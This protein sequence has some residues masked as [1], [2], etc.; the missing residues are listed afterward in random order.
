MWCFCF[1]AAMLSWVLWVSPG[2]GPCSHLCGVRW[3]S[4]LATSPVLAHHLST[5]GCFHGDHNSLHGYSGT[6]A[7]AWGTCP[8]QDKVTGGQQGWQAA[9]WGE[10]V[11]GSS[12]RTL[13]HCCQPQGKELSTWH[14]LSPAVSLWEQG[15]NPIPINHPAPKIP[16][17]VTACGAGSRVPPPCRCPGPQE[18][19]EAQQQGPPQ[20][21]QTGALFWSGSPCTCTRPTSLTARGAAAHHHPPGCSK[22]EQNMLK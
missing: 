18:G 19:R 5:A 14:S 6:L 1:S 22:A 20:G 10:Q 3:D 8:P 9:G 21:S 4:A 12:W 16:R 7:G 17:R 15:P 2:S 13:C 11:T